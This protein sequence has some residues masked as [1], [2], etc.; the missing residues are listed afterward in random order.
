MDLFSLFSS[1]WQ[2]QQFL[3]SFLVSVPILPFCIIHKL[4]WKCIAASMIATSNTFETF[5]KHFFLWRSV[6][7]SSVAQLCPTLCDPMNRS[8]PGLPKFIS[9]NLILWTHLCFWPIWLQDSKIGIFHI[10]YPVNFYTYQMLNSLFL[11]KV[12]SI[13]L[14]NLD[15]SEKKEIKTY[16]DNDEMLICYI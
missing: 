1:L 12:T 13:H 2:W 15:K 5:C 16:R 4:L 7:F 9:I 6:Q 8:T 10:C 3:S 14:K 11:I